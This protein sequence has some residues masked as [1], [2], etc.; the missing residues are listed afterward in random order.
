MATADSASVRAALASLSAAR[1]VSLRKRHLW[2]AASRRADEIGISTY[3]PRPI[4]SHGRAGTW[5][6]R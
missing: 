5:P 3:W 1:F 6:E 2:G 4:R